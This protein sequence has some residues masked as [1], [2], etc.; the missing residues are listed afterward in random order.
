MRRWGGT[1]KAVRGP[2]RPADIGK[3]VV[4]I[5]SRIWALESWCFNSAFTEGLPCVGLAQCWLLGRGL[6]AGAQ[7]GVNLMAVQVQGRKMG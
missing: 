2:L 7:P 4:D 1:G 5:Y 6:A 3:V